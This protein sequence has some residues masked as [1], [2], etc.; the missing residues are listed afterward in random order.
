MRKLI[1]MLVIALAL[2]APASADIVLDLD[3][4]EGDQQVRKTE[5][6]PGKTLKIEVFAQKGARD[7]QGVEIILRFNPEKV[8]YKSFKEA[9]LMEGAMLL[10]SKT[11]PGEAKI[12][13]GFL[14]KK[15]QIGRAHV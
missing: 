7:I 5:V 11:S 10:P 13:L 12:S 6:K 15:S 1:F 14:G 4:K 9:G 8:T 2:C 3:L